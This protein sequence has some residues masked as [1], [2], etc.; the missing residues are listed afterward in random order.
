MCFIVV[1]QVLLLISFSLAFFFTL[2]LS[3]YPPLLF[4]SCFS[5]F[6]LFSCI[7]L[8]DVIY[9]I[10]RDQ[11]P[12]FTPFP[13]FRLIFYLFPFVFIVSSSST[14]SH[15]LSIVIPSFS[16]IIPP[17]PYLPSLTS[18]SLTF[19]PSTALLPNTLHLFP[20]SPFFPLP[21]PQPPHLHLTCL[22]LIKAELRCLPSPFLSTIS[23]SFS[24][25][26][27]SNSASTFSS[28]YICL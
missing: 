27:P 6:L 22:T 16:Y 21:L 1:H 18:L 11:A 28:L 25:C 17:S 14:N 10:L 9:F 24:S 20:L 12:I 8:T 19:A 15:S 2:P 5:M 4:V 26:F 23:S 3:Y 13:Y 7:S